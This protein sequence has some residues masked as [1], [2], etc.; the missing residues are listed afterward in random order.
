MVEPFYSPHGSRERAAGGAK[1]PDLALGL[2]RVDATYSDEV[3]RTSAV[4]INPCVSPVFHPR[5][6]GSPVVIPI[7]SGSGCR[8]A[9]IEHGNK[10]VGTTI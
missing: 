1:D 2:R 4:G 9:E 5:K 6:I 3:R 10:I 7:V 8:C